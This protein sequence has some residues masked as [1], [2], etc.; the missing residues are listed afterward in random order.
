[1]VVLIKKTDVFS[2][3]RSNFCDLLSS[4]DNWIKNSAFTEIY[5]FF[6]SR[7]LFISICAG[8]QIRKEIK[9]FFC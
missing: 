3:L 7:T 8:Y 1:M 6:K 9:I 5:I 2:R 4:Y